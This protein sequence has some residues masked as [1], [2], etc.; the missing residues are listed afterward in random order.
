[1]VT[2]LHAE[3]ANNG[4][5]RHIPFKAIAN[6]T[7]SFIDPEYLPAR[8]KLRDPRNMQKSV[9]EDFFDHILQRQ[10]AQGLKRAFRFKGIKDTDGSVSP[11]HYPNSLDNPSSPS[12]HISK[13]SGRK[14]AEAML[15]ADSTTGSNTTELHANADAGDDYAAEPAAEP[16]AQGQGT[17]APKPHAEN[18][19]KAKPR[20]SDLAEEQRQKRHT[21]PNPPIHHK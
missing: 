12:Q 14:K 19:Q 4:R 8:F 5:S 20:Q 9:I 18:L 3:L 7:S 21:A 16:A 17:S 1:M 6:D 13:Q 2:H 15:D 10:M 11:A